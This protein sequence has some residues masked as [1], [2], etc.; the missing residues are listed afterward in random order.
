M[1]EEVGRMKSK[2]KNKIIVTKLTAGADVH[3]RAMNKIKN[4]KKQL[5][6][7]QKTQILKVI[8]IR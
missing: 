4:E 6:N 7:E 1:K 8:R 5:I 3:V 2:I